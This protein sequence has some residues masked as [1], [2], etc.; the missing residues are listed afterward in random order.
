MSHFTRDVDF[1][2]SCEFWHNSTAMPT[3]DAFLGLFNFK[4]PGVKE[5]KIVMMARDYWIFLVA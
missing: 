3:V 5:A 4:H 2:T 1:V